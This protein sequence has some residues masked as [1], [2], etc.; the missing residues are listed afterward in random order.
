M[1]YKVLVHALTFVFYQTRGTT[2]PIP[3]SGDYNILFSKTVPAETTV[4]DCSDVMP[5]LATPGIHSSYASSTGDTRAG[6]PVYNPTPTL[7]ADTP[8]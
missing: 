8:P 6:L 1:A 7:A 4:C 2:T 3:A 5:H